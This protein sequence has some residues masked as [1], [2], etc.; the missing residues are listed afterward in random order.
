MDFNEKVY[1][2]VAHIPIGRVTT[3]GAIARY[4]GIGGS[5]RMVGYALN[6]T[7]RRD[8]PDL[9]CHRV[10]NRLGQLTGKAAFSDG[11]MESLLRQEGIT[12]IAE[13]TVSLDQHFWDPAAHMQRKR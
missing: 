9:P 2:V 1:E 5:S 4:L 7:L 6:Q 12:F 11:V 3:Y 8:G 13:D 10:V